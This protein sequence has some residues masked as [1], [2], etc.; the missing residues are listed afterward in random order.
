LA[1][2][3]GYVRKENEFMALKNLV[4]AERNG[5]MLALANLHCFFSFSFGRDGQNEER[6]LGQGCIESS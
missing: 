3:A 4:A 5:A 6:L 1:I 2:K